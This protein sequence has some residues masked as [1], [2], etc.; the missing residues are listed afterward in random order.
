MKK[1]ILQK[2][3]D[4]KL[5]FYAVLFPNTLLRFIPDFDF[6][7]RTTLQLDANLYTSTLSVLTTLAL[8]LKKGHIIIFSKFRVP[9]NKFKV[10]R[11]FFFSVYINRKTLGSINNY[12]QIGNKLN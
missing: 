9:T 3:D 5:K 6:S 12:L 8:K 10:F 2:I 7:N 11:E 4:K 1:E